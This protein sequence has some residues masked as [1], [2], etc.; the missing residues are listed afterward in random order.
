MHQM[1]NVFFYV[2]IYPSIK[3]EKKIPL[4]HFLEAER[5]R[6]KTSMYLH[7][8]KFISEIKI[9]HVLFINRRLYVRNLLCN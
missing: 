4:F 6:N 2:C 3:Y 7:H 5:K 1:I 8:T 9:I